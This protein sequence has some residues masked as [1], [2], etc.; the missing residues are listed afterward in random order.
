MWQKW[1]GVHDIAYGDPHGRDESKNQQV[2]NCYAHVSIYVQQIHTVKIIP[3]V[4]LVCA[5]E[6]QNY[7]FASAYFAFRQNQWK[8]IQRHHFWICYCKIK[9]FTFWFVHFRLTRLRSTKTTNVKR[10]KM[11]LELQ[12]AVKQMYFCVLVFYIGLIC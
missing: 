7:A 1:G 5:P 11:N 10:T 12:K 3:F 4:G 2:W 6:I 8:T 9:Y